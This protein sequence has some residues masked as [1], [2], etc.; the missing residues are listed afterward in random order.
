MGPRG[1][2]Q[3]WPWGNNLKIFDKSSLEGAT[4]QIFK[5]LGLTVSDKKIILSFPI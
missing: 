2:G 5:A 3:F 1:K 4:H